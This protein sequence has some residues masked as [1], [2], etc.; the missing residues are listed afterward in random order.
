MLWGVE[1]KFGFGACIFLSCTLENLDFKFE[2]RLFQL[3]F[4]VKID[5]VEMDEFAV[6]LFF[7]AVIFILRD[8]EGQFLSVF[9]GT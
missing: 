4:I 6:V 3:K 9:G 7:K 2:V 8:G 5:E 1:D